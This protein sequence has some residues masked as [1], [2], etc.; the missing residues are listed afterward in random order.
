MV[1]L[2]IFYYFNKLSS[3]RS[4][5]VNSEMFSKMKQN[6]R[7]KSQ[8][9]S[10]CVCNEQ[11]EPCC[12]VRQTL[13]T[14]LMTAISC[15]GRLCRVLSKP[16]TCRWI[17]GGVWEASD[18]RLRVIMHQELSCRKVWNQET[19]K[20]T[21]RGEGGAEREKGDPDWWSE[22]QRCEEKMVIKCVRGF[23]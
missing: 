12:V 20:K 23:V 4:F 18:W 5:E 2:F 9:F 22:R 3:L 15:C 16:R 7:V 14:C 1:F 6:V 8:S 21:E 17:Q 19:T 10:S 13:S 11:T